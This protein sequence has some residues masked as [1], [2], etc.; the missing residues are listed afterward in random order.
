MNAGLISRRYA[1]VLYDYAEANSELVQAYTDAQTV[2]RAFEQE[3]DAQTMLASPMQSNADKK[4]FLSAV[5]GTYSVSSL[6]KFMMFVVDKGR[7]ALLSEILRVFAVVYRKRQ[8]I[9]SAEVTTATILSA[10]KQNEFSKMLADKMQSAIEV[11]YKTN[12]S[13]IGGIIVSVD[14]KQLDC[15]ISHQLK[16]IER[17]LMN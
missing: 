11:S 14:G 13:I 15:S 7:A 3:K 5:F 8:G 2:Y 16:E 10:V 17:G 1:T 4:A 12:D 9:K 6:M